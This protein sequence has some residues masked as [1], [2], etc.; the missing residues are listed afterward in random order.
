[1]IKFLLNNEIVTLENSLAELS[2]QHYLRDH[3]GLTGSKE[4]CAAG[5]CGACTVVLGEIAPSQSAIFYRSV[6]SCITLMASLHGKQLVT[7]EH[8]SDGQTLHPVQQAMVEHH[9]SQCGFCTPGFVMSM[10][11]LY[12]SDKV[13]DRE[14]INTALSGNLCRCTGYRPI[15]E[16]TMDSCGHRTPDKF[17]AA[18]ADILQQLTAIA[19]ETTLPVINNMYLPDNR[20]TMAT[21]LKAHPD[22]RLVAGSTDLSLEYTQQLK[23]LPTLISTSRVKECREVTVNSDTITIGSALPLNDIAPVLNEHFPQLHELIDR[24]A[25]LPI[26]NQATLGGNVANASPIGDMPPA[27]LALNAIIILD[28]GKNYREVPAREFFTGYRQTV[29]DDK[30]WISAVQFTRLSEQTKLRAYKV[31]KRHEDDISAVCAVFTVTLND[32]TVSALTTGF[33]GVAATPVNCDALEQQLIGKT[34]GDQSTRQLGMQI[35]A[36]AFSPIDDVRA[37]ADY[38]KQ[39]VVNLWQRFWF[40]TQTNLLATTR[41]TSYA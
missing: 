11:A 29:L 7:I 37:S 24:F 15:I 4:G 13:A 25:S 8:L 36:N 2:V 1:M 16:A 30:E 18:Q 28:D 38:R 5:D 14:T 40:E 20:A 3:K 26:R 35:L 6:N 17:S 34:W 27:L 21:L 9:G 39:L 41:V 12:H 10:F 19:S 23:P 33:G 22:A 31:S 32:G